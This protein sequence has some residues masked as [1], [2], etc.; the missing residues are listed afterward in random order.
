MV[1]R[2]AEELFKSLIDSAQS[3]GSG[4]TDGD[5]KAGRSTKGRLG[6]SA[7]SSCPSLPA[8]GP[9]SPANPFADVLLSTPLESGPGSKEGPGGPGTGTGGKSNSTGGGEAMDLGV[10]SP[11]ELSW[12][13]TLVESEADRQ[14]FSALGPTVSFAS[15]ASASSYAKPILLLLFLESVILCQYWRKLIAQAGTS[16]KSTLPSAVGRWFPRGSLPRA[17]TQVLDQQ[18]QQQRQT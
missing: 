1:T 17:V 6:D 14:L 18:R 8:E 4:A 7:I 13:A 2:N 9:I 15:A 5:T 16:T 12:A 10:V 3:R 11:V